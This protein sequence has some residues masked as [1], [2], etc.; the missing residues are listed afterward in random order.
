MHT[1]DRWMRIFT[2][3]TI[4]ACHANPGEG[5]NLHRG[6]IALPVRLHYLIRCRA[7]RWRHPSPFVLPHSVFARRI[8]RGSQ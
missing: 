6:T 7:E 5:R 2:A 3:G 1:F 4:V 8:V